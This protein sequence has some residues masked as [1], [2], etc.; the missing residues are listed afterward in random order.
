IGSADPVG[1]AAP[2]CAADAFGVDHEAEPTLIFEA[3]ALGG[4]ECQTG[5]AGNTRGNLSQSFDAAGERA[6]SIYCSELFDRH[7]ERTDRIQ[8]WQV[9]LAAR[10]APC[11]CVLGI[12][13]AAHRAN[14]IGR[15]RKFATG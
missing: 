14:L 12:Q 7:L 8:Q 9:C 15:Q 4:I 2:K 13:F 1:S 11:A 3:M 6:L 10:I 5:A